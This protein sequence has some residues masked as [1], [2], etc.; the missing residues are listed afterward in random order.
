MAGELALNLADINLSGLES[1]KIKVAADG[2][3]AA[4]SKVYIKEGKLDLLTLNDGPDSFARDRAVAGCEFSAS[5]KF[6]VVKTK[7]NMIALLP[8]LC[9]QP[10]LHKIKTRSGQYFNSAATSLPGT[11]GTK[12][13]LVSDTA[14]DKN[15]HL[16][17]DV[18]HRYSDAERTLLLASGTSNPADGAP[19]SDVFILLESMTHADVAVAGVRTIELG[20][21]YS[22]NMGEIRNA[23]F[24]AESQ[25]SENSVG[26]WSYDGGIKLT[27]ECEAKQTAATELTRYGALGLLLNDWRIT[28]ICGLILAGSGIMG[29]GWNLK[30]D[31]DSN[32][33][34][35]VKI[36]ATGIVPA[37]SFAALWT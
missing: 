37:S 21:S 10:I 5:A 30:H 9:T 20:P 12:W 17:V 33:S 18:K 7:A 26:A 23:K 6:P 1:W 34:A 19:A 28:F 27:L 2:G 22:D 15:M 31:K 11:Y 14:A 35:F 3:Y 29:L 16:Q 24:T 4:L 13:I 36:S 25:A 8:A 32:G